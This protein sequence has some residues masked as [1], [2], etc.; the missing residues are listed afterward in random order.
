VPLGLLAGDLIYRTW[1]H[2]QEQTD[3]QNVEVVRAV[4]VAIDQQVE[5]TIAALTVLTDLVPSDSTDMGDFYALCA[6]IAKSQQ[7]QSVRLAT[8]SG[9]IVFST[10]TPLGGTPQAM[11]MD[12][13][14]EAVAESRPAV[15]TV[16][17]DPETDRWIVTIGVPVGPKDHARYVLGARVPTSAFT[18]ILRRQRTP[19]NGVVTLLDTTPVIIAR[20]LNEG[21]YL[22]HLPTAD[23]LEQ[24]ESST[25]G[26]WRTTTLEGTPS[27]AAWSKSALTGWTV[28]IGLPAAFV[29]LPL[30]RSL[31][32]LIA[33]AVPLV[34]IG[35][36][37]AVFIHRRLVG[38][39]RAAAEAARALARGEPITSRLSSIAEIQDLSSA[40]TEAAGILDTRLRERDEAQQQSERQRTALLEREQA[41]RRAAEALSRAKDEFVATVSH[42]LRTQLNAIFGWVTLLKTAP[43]DPSRQKQ[44]LD[45]IHRNAAAQLTLIDDL[46]DMSRVLRGTVRLD[47]Q[48]V[49]L[50]GVIDAAVDALRPG[51][52]AR[53]I[54]IVISAERGLALVSADQSRVQQIIFNL[55]SN[56]LKFTPPDGRIDVR[57]ETEHDDAVLRVIDNGEGIAPEFLPFVFDRFRQEASDLARPHVGLGIGLSLVRHLTELHGGRISA[58]SDGKGLGATFTLRLPLL[59]ARAAKAV[60]APE[61][62]ADTRGRQLS[63]VRVL[64]VDDDADALEL[65]SAVIREAGGDPVAAASVDDALSAIAALAPDA[66]VSDIAMPSGNGYDFAQGLR[67]NPTT[68]RIPLVAVTAHAR[69]EDRDRAMAAGFDAHLGKPFEPRALVGLLSGLIAENIG[70]GADL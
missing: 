53:R 52:D 56:S 64:V 26:A 4:G 37:A 66:I 47:M 20:T 34:G 41:G 70:S 30:R 9:H 45:V 18:A 2:Q 6:R 35:L 49:D 33:I 17:K 14:G 16:R 10:E 5:H 25:E 46:M 68:K 27:Y 23:F 58:Q 51:G 62:E 40:L 13:V 36:V 31:I 55:V 50:A 12:W 43:M 11:N 59:G 8:P 15:S 24:S 29:D 32:A 21:T 38:A 54:A 22:G 7:W 67:A 57:L 19:A 48:P 60:A 42:E 63:G 39:Q 44:G 28:G 65:V 1:K 61:A 69:G 3:R